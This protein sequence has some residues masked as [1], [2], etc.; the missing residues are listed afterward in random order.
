MMSRST[1]FAVLAALWYLGSVLTLVRWSVPAVEGET[2]EI[3]SGAMRAESPRTIVPEFY[4]LAE[5]DYPGAFER[6]FGVPDPES[7]AEAL[8][9]GRA[10]YAREGCFHCH[11]QYV[12]AGSIDVER[13]GAA[14]S[15]VDL[16]DATNGPPFVGAR[17]VGPDLGREANRR[18][19]DWH[20]AHLYGPRTIASD[21]IMPR[22]PWLFETVDGRVVPDKEG[23]A[24]IVYL[25]SLGA[26]VGEDR[27]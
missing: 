7:Y 3:V 4:D 23:L 19:N 14:T 2:A 26:R 6:H 16:Y 25:Q 18:S 1:S 9:V 21:S 27:R 11:T 20:A 5:R 13:W 24:L 15:L 17:R 8:E 22:F 12:R 10:V